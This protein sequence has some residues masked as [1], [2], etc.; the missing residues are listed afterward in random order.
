AKEKR[1]SAFLDLVRQQ[2]GMSYFAK[3]DSE[4]NYPIGAGLASSASGF[5]ALAMAAA[6]A[7]N[8]HLSPEQLSVLARRGSGSAARSIFGGFVEMKVGEEPDGS[9]SFAAQIAD[10]NYWAL[11]LIAAITAEQEKPIG[12]TEGMRQTAQTSPYYRDWISSSRPDLDEMR[13]AIIKKDFE[14]LGE[15]SE[16]SCLKM[17]ALAMSAKP[18]LIYWHSA[19]IALIHLVRELRQKNIQCYFTIDAGPQVKILCFP[20]D[21]ERIENSL[22]K[23]NGVKK[24]IRTSLGPGAKLIETSS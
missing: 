5:A 17:H 3:V 19:T 12:S 15:I 7:A 11:N 16:Q 10:E 22:R 13:A 18:G 20:Q 23:F 8:L 21:A 9:D 1:V 2:A 6:H 14:K 4:N 24:T